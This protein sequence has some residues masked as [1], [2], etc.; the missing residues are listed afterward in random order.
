MNTIT[1]SINNFNSAY[2]GSTI[3]SG[4]ILKAVA[5]ILTL[6]ESIDEFYKLPIKQRL[7][8]LQSIK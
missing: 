3:G 6:L 2:I 4:E 5:K 8:T 1:D 7:N